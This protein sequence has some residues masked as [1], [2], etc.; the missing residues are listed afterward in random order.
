MTLYELQYASIHGCGVGVG[1]DGM[2]VLVGVIARV[3]VGVEGVGK[4]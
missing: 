1:V 3:G 2:A 4:P